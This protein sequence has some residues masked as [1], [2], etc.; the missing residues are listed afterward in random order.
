MLFPA[1]PVPPFPEDQVSTTENFLRYE[2]CTQDGRLIPIAIPPSLGGLWQS[3]VRNHP[4]ARNAI[5]AGVVPILTRLTLLSEDAPIRV[6]RPVEGRAGF[7]LA[8]DRD[9]DEVTRLFMNVWSEVRGIGGRLGPRPVEGPP[10]LA[11]R[12]F[13]EHTFTR[14]FA[15][16]EQRKITRFDIPGYPAI[17]ELR[18]PA[19][20]P[21][22][23][24]EAPEGARWV[25]ELAPDPADNVFG[26]D[27]TDA[28]QHVNSLVYIRIFLDAAQRRLASRG[29]APNVRSRAVDIAY[30]KPSFAGDR[31]RTHVRLF[32]HDGQ[33]GAAGHVEGADGKPRCYA[34]VLF[35]S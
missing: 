15:P 11:G 20:P 19:P 6:D 2:D 32:E 18:Y 26:L 34:R 10:V 17:P 27:Q 31:V 29:H 14:L 8:H 35:G 24:Q 13:A 21:R 3:V 5:T 9:G 22:T 28:N 7:V 12:L 4:G 16:P 30:R 23:A 1:P 33:L 25:D